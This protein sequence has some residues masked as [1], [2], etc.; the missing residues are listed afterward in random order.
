MESLA[1]IPEM[2]GFE[3]CLKKKQTPPFRYLTV[4]KNIL[5]YDKY[6]PDKL[7]TLTHASSP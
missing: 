7:M 1:E 3:E 4:L 6:P 5:T 2:K